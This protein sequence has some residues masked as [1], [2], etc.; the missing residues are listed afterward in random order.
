MRSRAMY[1]H[2]SNSVQLEMGN[3]RKCS[4]GCKRVL[5]KFHSSGRWALGCHWPKPSRWLKMRSLARA[6]SSSRRAPPIKASK[7]NSSIASSRVTDWCTLRL[8]PGWA[9]RTVPRRIESSTL[10]TIN[11]APSSWA[12]KSRKSVTSGKL[13]PVSIISRGKGRRPPCWR[14]MKAFS[15][16][17]SMT[18]ESLPPENNKVGRSKVAATSRR[19]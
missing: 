5:N 18:N 3:T 19:M 12:R 9:R 15:A 16:Q 17:R 10:R 4:P 6:F 1:C 14:S 2:T 13:W 8:S 7:R 11:S